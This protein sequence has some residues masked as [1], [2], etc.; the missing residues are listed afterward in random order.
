L[1][2]ENGD[3]LGRE[4]TA[5]DGSRGTVRAV[6]PYVD[7]CMEFLCHRSTRTTRLDVPIQEVKKYKRMKH[8]VHSLY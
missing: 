2:R 8:Q 4:E 7:G 1:R 5:F 3:E 6:V